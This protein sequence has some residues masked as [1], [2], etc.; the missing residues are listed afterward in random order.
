MNYS[1]ARTLPVCRLLAVHTASNECAGRVPRN[2]ASGFMLVQIPNS[3]SLGLKTVNSSVTE[4][5]I[6]FADSP[7]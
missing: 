1:Q 7:E 3:H 2:E 4:M 5:E 6:T